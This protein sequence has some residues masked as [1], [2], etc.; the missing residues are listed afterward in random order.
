MA[1]RLKRNK[2]ESAQH[3]LKRMARDQIDKALDEIDDA[4]LSQ[5]ETVHQVRKRCKKLRSLVRLYRPALGG[6]YRGLNREFRDTARLISDARDAAV[7]LATYDAVCDRFDDQID[8]RALASIRAGLTRHHRAVV[9]AGRDADEQLAEARKR[10]SE[11]RDGVSGWS[12]DEAGF[13]AMRGGLAKTYA[14]GKDAMDEAADSPAPERFHEWRKR[15]KYT[16]YHLRMLRPIWPTILNAYRKGYRDLT[17][18]L[19]DA[20]DLAVL[21]RFL[22]DAGEGYGS[23]DDVAAF[24]ALAEQRRAEFEA[25]A[26]PLGRKLYCDKPKRLLK[27][28]DAWW[29]AWHDA[30]AVDQ[31]PAPQPGPALAA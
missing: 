18:W 7:M 20:H 12:I 23:A 11:A 6:Q 3:A 22:R 27:R 8:R 10:L 30:A 28:F 15:A 9:E 1:F 14:R 4:K 24:V 26:L 31:A 29:D 21:A 25:A 13:D 16:R 17:D 19:G 2:P 5:A